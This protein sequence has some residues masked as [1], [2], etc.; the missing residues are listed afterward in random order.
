MNAPDPLR[1]DQAALVAELEAA[2]VKAWKG[3]NCRCPFHH[4]EHPSAGVYQGPD[5]IWRFKCMVCEAAGDIFDIRALRM[6]KTVEEVLREA[7]GT[8]TA[9]RVG[10]NGKRLQAPPET[11]PKIYKLAEFEKSLG[12][13]LEGTFA[14][15]DPQTRIKDM[16]V[17]RI[18]EKDGGK[19]FLQARPARDGEGIVLKA[20]EKPWP[21]YNRHYVASANPVIVVEGEKCVRAL[22]KIGLVATTSPGGAGKAGYADWSM[23]AG[24]TCYLWPDNDEPGFKHMA[25]VKEILLALSPPAK[26]AVIDPKPLNL[27]PKGDVVD[28]LE[29]MQE[30]TKDEQ[31]LSVQAMLAEY[32]PETAG[33]ELHSLI[34][35]TISGK[36]AC[37]RFPDWT[38]L[39]QA[40]QAMLPGT[41][42]LLCGGEGSTKS[43]MLL[44]AFWGW[45]SR[46]VKVALYELEEDRAHHTNRL[47]ALLAANPSLT[48]AEWLKEHADEARAVEAKWRGDIDSFGER[49]TCAPTKS[50]TLRELAEWAKAQVAGGARI[51]GIDPVTSAHQDAKP[52]VEDLEFVN[53]IKTT[54]RQYEAS[55][56]LVTHPRAQGNKGRSLDDMAGGRAYPRFSQT[57]LWLISQAPDQMKVRKFGITTHE[58]VNRIVR[59]N[60][61]RNSWGTGCQIGFKFNPSTWEIREQ[62]IIEK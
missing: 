30:H 50:R 62:G 12:D 41:V 38:T 18:R 17:F 59:V 44:S 53:E 39:S 6:G 23:L 47:L 26:V 60:K 54:M 61:A 46:G 16:I 36:R 40:T 28:W 24:K 31:R 15:T 34:E 9:L 52:W 1:F 37:P 35:D 21:I 58:E 56:I 49:M 5:K 25:E 14:Y 10:G 7:H 55:A 4:D 20:P 51:I 3:R 22:H 57:V 43:I 19:R 27:Q 8:P 42:T 48:N 2:G 29:G 33:G 13:A 11:A 32:S 45:H